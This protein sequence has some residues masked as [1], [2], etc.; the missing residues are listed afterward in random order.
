M[1]RSIPIPRTILFA[2]P[3]ERRAIF[4]SVLSIG[5]TFRII[6]VGMANSDASNVG[7]I[8]YRDGCGVGP[9]VGGGVGN[10]LGPGVGSL[11][12]PIVGSI[13]DCTVG[14]SVGSADGSSVG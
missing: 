2:P 6:I 3:C 4:M 7:A 12:G 13:D 14:Y 10:R 1:V 11:V 8:G 5:S 9:G